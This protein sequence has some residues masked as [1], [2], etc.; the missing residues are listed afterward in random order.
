MGLLVLISESKSETPGK[1]FMILVKSFIQLNGSQLAKMKKS[2]PD[3][4]LP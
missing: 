4:F 1:I 3:M 2:I